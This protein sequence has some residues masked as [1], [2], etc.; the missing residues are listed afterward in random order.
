MR[1]LIANDMGLQAPDLR[2]HPVA[3]HSAKCGWGRGRRDVFVGPFDHR[4]EPLLLQTPPLKGLEAYRGTARPEWSLSVPITGEKVTRTVWDHL[5]PNLGNGCG[6]GTCRGLNS[7]TLRMRGFASHAVGET[8][9]IG[10][11]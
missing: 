9:P 3:Q 1:I 11:C 7:G 5:G 10:I 6:I 4:I 8:N 2:A